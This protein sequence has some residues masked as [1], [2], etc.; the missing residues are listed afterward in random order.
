MVL[1]MSKGNKKIRNETL[2]GINW[3]EYMT[4]VRPKGNRNEPR[5]V[6]KVDVQN[7]TK[8]VKITNKMIKER[9][10]TEKKLLN[11]AKHMP[12]LIKKKKIKTDQILKGFE[13]AKKW[14][15]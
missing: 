15:E 10:R 2:G 7:K 3:W 8:L 6:D 9:K 13:I 12:K 5:Y 1:N 14:S 4:S 11:I